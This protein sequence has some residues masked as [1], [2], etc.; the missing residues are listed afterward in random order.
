MSEKKGG[1]GGTQNCYVLK[2]IEYIKL[3]AFKNTV[4]RLLVAKLPFCLCL[5]HENCYVQEIS[6]QQ[7][8]EGTKESTLKQVA[9]SSFQHCKRS[10]LLLYTKGTTMYEKVHRGT[11]RYVKVH[12]GIQR[13]KKVQKGTKRYKKVQ[14][15]TKRY[16]KAQKVQKGT[17]R[18]KWYKK[19]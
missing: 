5:G 16:K 13:Y 4:E 15:G 1:Q 14:K 9:I 6:M 19:V 2:S 7:N 3:I 18:L 8:N 10:E 17:K 12:K 11:Q